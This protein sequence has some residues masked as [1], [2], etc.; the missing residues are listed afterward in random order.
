VENSEDWERNYYENK[1]R[2]NDL[3]KLIVNCG[4][5]QL[6]SKNQIRNFEVRCSEFDNYMVNL[7][8]YINF[9]EEH[10]YA[11]NH[12]DFE[13]DHTPVVS[14]SKTLK[15]KINMF[16]PAID[17]RSSRIIQKY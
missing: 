1:K 8:K 6:R 15:G 11:E 5:Y 17:S 10:P 12:P 4:A 13:L 2:R 14:F 9:K 7:K 16:N 3:R